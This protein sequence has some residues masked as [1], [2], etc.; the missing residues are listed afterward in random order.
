MWYFLLRY[1]LYWYEAFLSL[2][3]I[4]VVSKRQ[5]CWNRGFLAYLDRRNALLHLLYYCFTIIARYNFVFSWQEKV[6]VIIGS[7]LMLASLFL[8][9]FHFH[10]CWPKTAALYCMDLQFHFDCR[11]YS[12]ESWC[13]SSFNRSLSLILRRQ[14][15]SR[16]S[17]TS[18]GFYLWHDRCCLGEQHGSAFQALLLHAS[19]LAKVL[20]Y[21]RLQEAQPRAKLVIC[22]LLIIMPDFPAFVIALQVFVALPFFLPFVLTFIHICRFF[23]YRLI[24]GPRHRSV[25]VKH[26]LLCDEPPIA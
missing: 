9:R 5:L 23:L 17:F 14:R 8:S 11:V 7:E 13:S 24:L 25:Y 15:G 26:Q 18:P 6:I 4:A 21:D 19:T 3:Q 16:R 20:N 1:C 10:R 12:C 2:Q 22:Q